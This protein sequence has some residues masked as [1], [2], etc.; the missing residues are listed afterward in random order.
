M[1]GPDLIAHRP[2]SRRGLVSVAMLIGLIILGLV[3]ASLLKVGMARRT[4]AKIE[5]HE[6]QAELLAES[7]VSRALARLDANPRYEGEVWEVPNSELGGRGGATVTITV[8]ADSNQPDIRQ[9]VVN[10][11]YRAGSPGSIRLTRTL[12]LPPSP[13]V[14]R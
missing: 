3:A 2:E 12:H 8:K 7:G 10:A 1:T 4:L 14:A 11:D 13:P 5:E 9:V 6:L